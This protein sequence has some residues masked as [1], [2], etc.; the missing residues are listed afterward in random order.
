MFFFDPFEILAPKTTIVVTAYVPH[1]TH[2]IS[3]TSA[4]S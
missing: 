1:R 3:L 2:K 4:L